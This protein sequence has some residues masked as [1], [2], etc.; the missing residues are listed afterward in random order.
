MKAGIK[1]SEKQLFDTTK[2]IEKEVFRL[3]IITRIIPPDTKKK[4]KE[5]PLL[6]MATYCRVSTEHS[7]QDTILGLQVRYYTQWIES[8]PGWVNAGIFAEKASGLSM[9]RRKKFQRLLDSYQNGEI[10]IAL[11]KSVNLFGR[12]FM[13]MF[14]I[15]RKLQSL[16]V[17]VFFE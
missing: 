17:N 13:E 2:N 15:L 1:L 9:R 11:I 16:D 12:D 7:E 10:N 4:Q 5:K 3:R 6:C 8:T 14:K